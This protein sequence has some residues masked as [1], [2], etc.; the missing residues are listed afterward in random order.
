MDGI[1]EREV[2]MTPY[3]QRQ[4]RVL[5]KTDNELSSAQR[6]MLTRSLGDGLTW[7]LHTSDPIVNYYVDMVVD[8]ELKIQQWSS[9]HE[10][11]KQSYEQ[12]ALYTSA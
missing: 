2:V 8:D 3:T 1:M 9:L 7:P 6:A 5:M 10:T 4:M 12:E 11:V